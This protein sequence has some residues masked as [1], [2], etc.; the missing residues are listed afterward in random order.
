MNMLKLCNVSAPFTCP[1]DRNSASTSNKTPTPN[2]IF[3]VFSRARLHGWI[4]TRRSAAYFMRPVPEWNS[5]GLVSFSDLCDG[6]GTRLQW[7][8]KAVVI[9]H[10]ACKHLISQML[11]TTS[12]V[13]RYMLHAPNL[14]S[15]ETQ[16]LKNLI[17]DSH[18][19]ITYYLSIY[20]IYMMSMQN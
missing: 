18:N 19:N 5:L 12:R 10:H 7:P 14:L 9:F 13:Y 3:T 17:L 4:Q 11:H 2:C 6:L 1:T 15:L 16:P 20:M 8:L